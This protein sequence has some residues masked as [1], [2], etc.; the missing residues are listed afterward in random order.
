[1]VRS[2]RIAVVGLL[3]CAGAAFAQDWQ[4]KNKMGGKV[5]DEAGKPIAGVT[6]KLSFLQSKTGPEAT[7]DAKGQWKVENI[8]EGMWVVEFYHDGFDPRQIPV[9]VGGKT[10]SPNIE[11]RLTK[12]G[13]DPTFAVQTGMAKGQ[14]LYQTL[15]YAEARAVYEGLLAKYPQVTQLNALIARSYHMEKNYAKAAEHLQAF[16]TANPAD[17]QMKMLLGNELIEAGRPDEAWKIYSEIDPAQ[18]KEALDLETPGFT[19]LR[20]KKPTEALK[21]FELVVTRF[22][23]DASGYYYR[24]FASWHAMGAVEDKN[25][26]ERKELMEKAKADLNKFLEMAPTANEASTAKQILSELAK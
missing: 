8:A 13:T 16:V 26:P 9:Q 21:Y 20:Q 5:V 19:L 3:V 10:K 17:A 6:V 14:Q 18:I 7:S 12:E 2:F 25:S 11:L 1:M 22:P 23:E 15:K 4:G 24:G